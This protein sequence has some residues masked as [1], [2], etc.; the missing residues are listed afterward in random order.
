MDMNDIATTDTGVVLSSIFKDH[1]CA[2]CDADA[3]VVIE[4]KQNKNSS[5]VL[6]TYLCRSHYDAW[7]FG[8]SLTWSIDL[9]GVEEL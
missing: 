5:E 8:N 4:W 2:Y 1:W 9:L 7:E 3:L 6:K